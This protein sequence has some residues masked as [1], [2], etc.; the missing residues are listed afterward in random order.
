MAIMKAK[1]P[2]FLLGNLPIQ[3]PKIRLNSS[4]FSAAEIE[5]VGGLVGHTIAE[6]ERE[7]IRETLVRYCGNRT[8]AAN[9]LDISIRALRNKIRTYTAYGIPVPRPG[10][11][12]P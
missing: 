4:R 11:S 3:S 6:I 1:M 2:N 9:V 5:I 10:Q 12:R 7:L 8:H